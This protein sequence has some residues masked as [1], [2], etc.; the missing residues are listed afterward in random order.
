MLLILLIRTTWLKLIYSQETILQASQH[1]ILKRSQHT[2]LQKSKHLF[3]NVK[4]VD[5]NV[6][7]VAKFSD[8]NILINK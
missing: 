4:K 1:K 2:I 5:K 7:N 6:V 8:K 3:K